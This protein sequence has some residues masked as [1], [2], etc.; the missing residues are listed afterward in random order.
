MVLQYTDVI[1]SFLKT[2]FVMKS[3]IVCISCKSKVCKFPKYSMDENFIYHCHPHHFLEI[4]KTRVNEPTG[5]YQIQHL[6]QLQNIS[7][8]L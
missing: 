1:I 7:K 8:P 5:S 4:F 2:L 6:K 3:D